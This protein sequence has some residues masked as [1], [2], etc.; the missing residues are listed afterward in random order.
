M[1]TSMLSKLGYGSNEILVFPISLIIGGVIGLYLAGLCTT[2]YS[3]HPTRKVFSIL[4]VAAVLFFCA[5]LQD[6]SSSTYPEIAFLIY[7]MVLI[8][9][10]PLHLETAIELTH[11]L[12]D[13]GTAC[14]IPLALGHWAALAG[15][16]FVGAADG[17]GGGTAG[18]GAGLL[19]P[20]FK[21]GLL[22]AAAVGG[23]CSLLAYGLYRRS[24]AELEDDEQ[25]QDEESP[26][27]SRSNKKGSR[28]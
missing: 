13:P 20:R 3:Y 17:G 11:G 23:A 22:A 1:E 16:A 5:W 21:A 15:Y 6:S 25:S 12:A 9:L 24:E 18:E 4:S 8:P 26:F 7:G 10:I 27:A 28:V 14:G 2:I 19:A